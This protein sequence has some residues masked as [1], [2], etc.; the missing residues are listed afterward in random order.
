MEFSTAPHA[1]WM[2]DSRH[3]VISFSTG[4]IQPALWLADFK[5]EK[6]RK[7]TA[8]TS[9]ESEPSLSPRGERLA[10]T[11]ITEDNDLM[12]LPLD[13]SQPRTL[14]PA[15]RNMYSPS[16]A[17]AGDQ[18]LYVTD[19]TGAAEIWVHN[20]KA[21]IDRPMVTQRDFPPGTTKAL[22]SP[23]FSPDGSR[24][25]FVRFSTDRPPTI[26]VE[27]AVGGPLIRLT[28]EY[29]VSPVWSPDGNS[30]A[31]LMQRERPWQPAIVGVGAD[32]S[33]HVIPG[34]TTCLTP[35]AWSS[36]GEWLA[37]GVREGIELF[38]PDGSRRRTLPEPN[39]SALVFTPDGK[40][41][42]A[43]GRAGG[44][45]FVKAI[46]VATGTARDIAQYSDGLT[47]SGTAAYQARI[48]LS[49]DRRSLATSA[50]SSQSDLWLLDGY[51]GPRRWWQLWR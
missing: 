5:W 49:P 37:C 11:S 47:I 1:S 18:L 25:A 45:T 12:E 42:Y 20:M 22:A 51:P 26:W 41:V 3:A 36:T 10:F 4:G 27:P 32:M 17:P 23:V 8:S 40:A 21:G 46:D 28:S 15:S 6:L 50:S 35:L 29:I 2:P 30:I 16:W 43:A 44:R 24:F 39:S 48:S 9:A 7:L 34:N 13:G 38:S 33:P 19:R 14:L 31:G